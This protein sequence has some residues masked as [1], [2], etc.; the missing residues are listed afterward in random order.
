VSVRLDYTRAPG[1]E[2][3]PDERAARGAIAA[4]LGYDPAASPSSADHTLLTVRL[5][6]GAG[7]FVATAER[8]DLA[9]RVLWTRPPLVDADCRHLIDVLGMAIA[10]ELDPGAAGLAPPAPP[11]PEP[12]PPPPLPPPPPPAPPPLAAPR[13]AFRIGARAGVSLGVL[14]GP[15]P[16][17]IAEVGV[18]WPFFSLGLE[19]RADLPITTTVD[20]GV[21]LRTSALLASLVPCG[22][23]RWLFGCG[24]VAVGV[25][26]AEGI[27]GPHL[28]QP[29]ADSGTYG[30]VGLRAGVEWPLP[31]ASWL[32]LRASADALVTIQPRRVLVTTQNEITKVTTQAAIWTSP[33]FSGLF[34]AGFALRF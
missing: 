24:V 33:P 17:V 11:P 1:A 19:G 28:T 7:G 2:A 18:G 21:Q 27:A 25:L 15:A 34:T 16:S 5:A 26:R 4:K 31:G 20:D 30:A 29:H 9:G 13:P 6:R 14:P 23:W 3:C 22:H 10:I 8:R 32:A 12:P